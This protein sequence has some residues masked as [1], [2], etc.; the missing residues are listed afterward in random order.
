MPKDPGNTSHKR[1]TLTAVLRRQM[2][3][4]ST[5]HTARKK[6]PVDPEEAREE[7]AIQTSR[8]DHVTPDAK[9]PKGKPGMLK[10]FDV[11]I[12]S[13]DEKGDFKKLS[14]VPVYY[15]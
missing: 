10:R 4:E 2:A 13:R 11:E 14:V 7:A 3:E 6:K 1:N 12:I 5:G 8:T 9:A 15:E